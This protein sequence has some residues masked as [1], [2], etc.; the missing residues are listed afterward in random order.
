[1]KRG[2]GNREEKALFPACWVRRKEDEGGKRAVGE[3]ITGNSV[4]GKKPTRL[5]AATN[6]QWRSPRKCKTL[7]MKI[8]RRNILLVMI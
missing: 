5:T 2:E 4:S 8:K 6:K 1:M 3:D 7:C